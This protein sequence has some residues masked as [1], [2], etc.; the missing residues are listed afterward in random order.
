MSLLLIIQ[1]ETPV[2]NQELPMRRKVPS[3]Y[4]SVIGSSSALFSMKYPPG[5]NTETMTPGDDPFHGNATRRVATTGPVLTLKMKR[6][7]PFSC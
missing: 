3:H 7:R 1:L 6:E 4:A 2:A 5:G